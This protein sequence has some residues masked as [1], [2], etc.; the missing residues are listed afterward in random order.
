MLYSVDRI[1]TTHAGA[2]PRPAALRQQVLAASRGEA[3]D[4]AEL[5]TRLRSGI[6]ETVERQVASGI[7]IVNDGE[8]S[9]FSFTEYVRSRIAGYELVPASEG[10]RLEI[11]ARDNRKFPDYIASKSFP[12]LQRPP[13]RPVCKDQLRYIGQADRKRDIDNFKQAL[14]G[15]HAAGSFFSSVS[16]GAIEHWLANRYYRDDEA[17]LFAIADAMREEYRAIVEAGLD[18]QI[19]APD[20][21]DAWNCFPDMTLPQ[22]RD[23]AMLRVDAVNHALRDLPKD[24]TRMHVCWGSFHGPHHDDVPLKDVVDILFRMQVGSYSIEASNPGHEHEWGIF[25]SV[26]LPG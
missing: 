6:S 16:P 11:T 25:E 20:L 14:R 9:K 3:I 21:L 26:K 15:A 5:Q 1:L 10:R 24:K 19:D 23:Y 17:F 22:Y 12:W 4:Q 2:L 7:D 13:T 8:L 18:L